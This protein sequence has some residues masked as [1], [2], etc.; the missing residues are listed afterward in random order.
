MSQRP[1]V[2][3]TLLLLL[4]FETAAAAAPC[5]GDCNRNGS[6]SIIELVYAVRIALGTSPPEIC[7]WSGA[8]TP[9]GIADLIRAV[10]M[11]L[12]GCPAGPTATA[13]PIEAPT[14]RPTLSPDSELYQT[15]AHASSHAC[16]GNRDRID[17]RDGLFS[18][19]CTTGRG[20]ASGL[21]VEVYPSEYEARAVFDHLAAAGSATEFDGFPAASLQYMDDYVPFAFKQSLTWLA[22]CGVVRAWSSDENGYGTVADPLQLSEGVVEWVRD[23]VVPACAD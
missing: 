19:G 23:H 15:F 8:E 10:R 9:I 17:V 18:F 4:V 21:A 13:T 1:T 14:A 20:H 16:A 11:A 12:E 2:A 6:V 7:R 5:P 22:A 3:A